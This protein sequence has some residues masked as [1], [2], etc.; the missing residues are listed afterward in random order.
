MKTG[1]VVLFGPEMNSA[2]LMSENEMMKAKMKPEDLTLIR[3]TPADMPSALQRGDIDA[4]SGNEPNST[5]AVLAGYGIA[6]QDAVVD[7]IR[8][9][10]SALH[11]FVSLEIAGGFA[12]ARPADA[13]F[14]VTVDA[15]DHAL[16]AWG[17][18]S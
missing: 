18:A 2:R 8:F 17:Q 7:A 14:E 3:L 1:S 9:L 16:A 4:F 13:S 12:M 11:G 6:D 15:L 10:R 5:T